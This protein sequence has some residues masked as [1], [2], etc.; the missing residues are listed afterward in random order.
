MSA[1]WRRRRAVV[2]ASEGGMCAAPG[3]LAAP[4]DVIQYEGELRG[5]CRS[6]RLRADA[7]QRVAKARI[8]RESRK[9]E[10]QLSLV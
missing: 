6:C 7:K 3:C 9:H 1:E 10:G 4:T 8:T 5:F 2:L